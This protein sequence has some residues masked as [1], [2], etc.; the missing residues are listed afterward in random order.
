VSEHVIK[1][2]DCILGMKD[3][4]PGSVDLAFADPPFNIGYEYDI[5]EDKKSISDYLSWSEAWIGQ[6]HQVLSPT[7]SFWIAIGPEYV[8][9]L[10]VIAKRTGFRKRDQIIWYY[11]FGVNC[12]KR[13][14]RSTAHLLYYTKHRTKF[15]FNETQVRIP[16]ARQMVYNDKRANPEG[17]LPDNT[18]I[19]RPQEAPLLFQE[20]DQ[21]WH[22]P[23]IN[24][25]FKARQKMVACQMPEQLMGRIIRISSNEGDLVLD[26]FAGSGSTIRTAKKLK[27]R[28]L[29]FELSP[30][31]RAAA[32]KRVDEVKEGDPLDTPDIQ[33]G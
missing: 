1:G 19:Y 23:R 18:W 10:D 13:F 26:S 2:G 28:G 5:Y 16:S 30:D 31:Y 24:G 6:T 12:A 27:R 33:G 11:T 21:V 8:S 17:R 22:C 14:T 25:T 32:Q 20:Q 4:E 15:T 29:A 3:L 9:E 7:G